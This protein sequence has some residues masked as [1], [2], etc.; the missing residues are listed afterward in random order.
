MQLLKTMYSYFKLNPM[1]SKILKQKRTFELKKKYMS[2]FFKIV[3]NK[4]VII[5][6]RMLTVRTF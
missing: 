2:I 3:H 4:Q 5:V 6:S 1:V